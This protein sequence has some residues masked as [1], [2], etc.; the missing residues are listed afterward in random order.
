MEKNILIKIMNFVLSIALFIISIIFLIQFNIRIG[1]N[2]KEIIKVLDNYNIKEEITKKG[3]YEKLE[4]KD[5]MLMNEIISSK[6]FNEYIKENVKAMYLNIFYDENAEYVDSNKLKSFVNNIIEEQEEDNIS[7]VI[8]EIVEEIDNS[9][10]EVKELKGDTK[11]IRDIFS[12]KTSTILLIGIILISLIIMLINSYEGLIWTGI[13]YI[14]TGSLFLLPI[15]TI[16]GTINI[17]DVDA[18][19][20]EFIYKYLITLLKTIKISCSIFT[21]VG[22]VEIIIYIIHKYKGE[23]NA[24]DRSI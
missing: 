24:R 7:N 11:I 22:I 1:I 13:T 5:K 21:I 17:I 12:K 20:Y 4:Y 16:N 14:I 18:T 2:K 15:L 3:S 8:N 9:V 19:T 6:E 23:E 10:K